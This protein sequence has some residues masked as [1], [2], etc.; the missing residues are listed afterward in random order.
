M[1]GWLALAAACEA[2]PV[3]FPEDAQTPD[4]EVERP[5][6]ATVK[7]QAALGA[8]W[9][10]A[11]EKA[12]PGILLRAGHRT[13]WFDFETSLIALTDPSPAFD[14]RLLGSQFGFYLMFRPLYAKRWE[15]ATGL[16]SDIYSLWNVHGDEW[17]AAFSARVA[18]HFWFLDRAGIFVTARAY[19]IATSGLELGVTRER[20]RGLPILFGTGVEWRFR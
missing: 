8:Q 20:A 1:L 14:A 17:Q 7:G 6:P 18:G 16:G 9:L 2:P 4:A 15:I 5:S 11:A 12:M 19:P 10:W 3:G 13:L